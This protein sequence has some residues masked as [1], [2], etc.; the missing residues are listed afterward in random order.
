MTKANT[1]AICIIFLIMV[2]M[3]MNAWTC[4]VTAVD[5]PDSFTPIIF[6]SLFG[7][8]FGLGIAMMASILTDILRKIK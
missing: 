7:A 1:F 6:L 8:G 3:L 2:T 4:A 5:D